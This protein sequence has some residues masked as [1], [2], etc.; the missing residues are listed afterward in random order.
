M[1]DAQLCFLPACN[2]FSAKCIYCIAEDEKATIKVVWTC[3][4]CTSL[5]E[6]TEIFSVCVALVRRVRQAWMM[7][8]NK[9]EYIMTNKNQTAGG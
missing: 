5:I 2:P 9:I 8:T 6:I 4:S 3:S 7:D 1:P